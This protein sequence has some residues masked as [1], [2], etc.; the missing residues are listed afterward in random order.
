VHAYPT[1]FHA[2][3]AGAIVEF[4]AARNE[5]G[6]VLLVNSCA[7]GKA[8][9]ESDLDMVVLVSPGTVTDGL[10]ADWERFRASDRRI[11]AFLGFG[12]FAV[13][14]V[15]IEEAVIPLPDHPEDEYPDWFELVI[16]N[17]CVW[18]VALWER[19]GFHERFRSEWLPFYD[20]DLR[21]KRLGEVR[22]QC[23]D[24]LSFIPSYVER[25]LY[26]Q[27]FSRLWRGFQLFLQALFLSRRT[28]PIA[29]DKWIHEQVADVLGL[30]DLYAQLPHLF[31]ISH[32]ESDELV[33]RGALLQRL[34]DENVPAEA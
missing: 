7:R 8:T 29:Y 24:Y 5:T 25:E 6:A 19:D 30:P 26:F 16:G 32:F 11:A 12:P 28:Y 17:W 21:R 27:A 33:A 22:R 34:L 3:A 18:G 2:D 31:E 10:R 9:S 14:H 20:E 1:T 23:V 4:F 15:D 13:L